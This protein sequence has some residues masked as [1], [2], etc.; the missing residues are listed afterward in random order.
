MSCVREKQDPVKVRM[1]RKVA[2]F[3]DP[4]SSTEEAMTVT[5]GEARVIGTVG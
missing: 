2:S 3:D 1:P 5:K 4:L